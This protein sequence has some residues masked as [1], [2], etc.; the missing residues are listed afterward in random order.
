MIS[1]V[2]IINDASIA[3]GGATG[4]AL[5]SARLLTNRGIKV[6]FISGDAGADFS[7]FGGN[8]S[9]YPIGEEHILKKSK[10]QALKSGL[11]NVRSSNFLKAWI[12]EHDDEKTIYHVHGWSKILSPSLFNGL[13]RVRNR[14]VIHA[15]DF[16]LACPN[17]AYMDYKSMQICNRVPLGYDCITTNCDKRS[18]QEKIWRMARQ[19]GLTRSMRNREDWAKILLIHEEMIPGL[20][21]AGYHPDRLR[22][23]RNP[24]TPFS[25]DRVPVEDNSMFFYVGRVEAEKGITDLLTAAQSQ[26]IDLT[27][28]GDGPLLEQLRNQYPQFVFTGWQESKKIKHHIKNARCVVMPSRYPEPFGLVAAEAIKSGIPVILPDTA[29]LSKDLIAA[30][31][32]ISFE[33]AN[34]DALSAALRKVQA[35]S[36]TQIKELSTAAF[37]NTL[38]GLSPNDWAEALLATYEEVLHVQ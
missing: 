35:M 25:D 36:R 14:T 11:Y 7:E 37:T 38:V 6:C 3:K 19:Y 1:K 17:G 33:S 4:L 21:R 8:F 22:T 30:G 26:N 27:V 31:S 28:I 2:V 12:R 32:G 10:L 16:F 18:Y 29:L 13:A 34:A 23:I 24:V 5:L 15:H 20:K 9:A